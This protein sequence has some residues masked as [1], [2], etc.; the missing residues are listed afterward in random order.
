M[1]TAEI[2]SQSMAPFLIMFREALEAAL[3]VGI[4]Y[5]YLQ[6]IERKD[7]TPYLIFGVISAVVVS[8]AA[9]FSL[10]Y[11]FGGLS[12]A[13]E[14]MFEGIASITATVVLTY[15]I[16]WMAKNAS[17]IKS[18]METKIQ[19]SLS[20]GYLF[21]ITSLAFVAVVREGIETV[22]FMTA[23]V[24]TNTYSTFI[25]ITLGIISVLVIS[26]LMMR[27]IR[28]LNMQKFF[29]Y[30]SLL[31]VI[32]AAGLFGYGIHELLEAGEILNITFGALSQPA[33]NINP[34][35]ISNPFHEKGVIGSILKALVGYDGNPEWLR[36]I[37]YIGYWVGIGAYLLRSYG[38]KM[39]ISKL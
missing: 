17:N 34:A 10:N 5:A 8:L 12:G 37:G 25:G 22:L 31:L 21:G 26:I 2:L 38:S 4:I 18:T 24:S 28:R 29:K 32:F 20:K 16:F 13:S 11:Y 3:I 23:L 19:T 7:I 6:K 14:K 9:G 27:G 35:D 33:Y 1:V 36:V 39:K 30:T 15:M